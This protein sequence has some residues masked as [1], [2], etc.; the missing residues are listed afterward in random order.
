MNVL[1]LNGMKATSQIWNRM[2]SRLVQWNVEYR[3][4]PHS[5]TESASNVAA[6]TA[7]IYPT[8]E[9]RAYDVLIGHSMGGLVALEL[10]AFYPVNVRKVILVESFLKPST[11]FYQNLM[12]PLHM[13]QYGEEVLQMIRDE[14]PY[15]LPTLADS[16][17]NQFD[18]THLLK[19]LESEVG[20]IYG[21]RGH[22][23]HPCRID[24]LNLEP[25][26]LQRMNIVFVEDACHMPMVEN[27]DGLM[28]ELVEMIR[29]L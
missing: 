7:G 11:P 27:P 13:E 18:Y 10:A 8:L 23:N 4:Y 28:D 26:V 21:D 1:L 29:S 5:V 19:S 25:D 15:Y 3:E 20:A 9:R 12:T 16:L 24:A 2:E 6:I 22:R 14:A 17:Q